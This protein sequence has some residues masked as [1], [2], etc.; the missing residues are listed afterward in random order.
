MGGHTASCT[1][2]YRPVRGAYT[3]RMLREFIESHPR[4]VVLTGA[5]VSTGS[6]IPDYRDEDGEWKRAPPVHFAPFMTRLEVRQRYW[7]RSAVGWP[8]ISRARPNAA[9]HSLAGLEALG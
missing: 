4:L 8:L 3:V 2:S 5:G 9:H 1:G 7:S 6:G